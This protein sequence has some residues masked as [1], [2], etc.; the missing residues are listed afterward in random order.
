[1]KEVYDCWDCWDGELVDVGKKCPECGC[2]GK[3]EKDPRFWERMVRSR[4]SSPEFQERVLLAR[5][6]LNIPPGGWTPEEAPEHLLIN[7]LA[8]GISYCWSLPTFQKKLLPIKEEAERLILLRNLGPLAEP[9]TKLTFRRS[10]RAYAIEWLLSA[11]LISSRLASWLGADNTYDIF[12]YLMCPKLN[13]PSSWKFRRVAPGNDPALVQ[14]HR[15]MSALLPIPE[16][17]MTKRGLRDLI[18]AS[19]RAAP[20]TKST[21]LEE[22]RAAFAATFPEWG[23]DY[24]KKHEVRMRRAARRLQQ[25][26]WLNLLSTLIR[27]IS[28]LGQ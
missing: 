25:E 5:E 9:A 27:Q 24:P 11:K 21:S 3:R 10:E 18:L 19:A 2:R 1:M 12:L 14:L 16:R 23:A 7:Y 17:F 15:F 22:Q 26:Q 6:T 4:L 28:Q 13:P 20:D 8:M